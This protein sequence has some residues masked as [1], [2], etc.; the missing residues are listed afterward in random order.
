MT[1]NFG[2]ID[3]LLMNG[4]HVDVERKLTNQDAFDTAV[5]HLLNQ[6][7]CCFNASGK[8]RYRSSRGK[9]AIGALIPDQLYAATMEGKTIQQLL[10]GS[11]AGPEGLREH[12]GGVTISLLIELQDLH[13]RIGACLPSLFRHLMLS[14]CDRIAKAFGLS[15]RLAH[16]WVAYH[17]LPG[18]QIAKAAVKSPVSREMNPQQAVG[19]LSEDF[20]LVA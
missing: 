20:K 18:P 1:G 11:K 7:H 4:V 6:G 3:S 17:R 16:L 14:G 15:S 10:P 13:D 19:R 5:L 2:T 9:S 12:L 8:S